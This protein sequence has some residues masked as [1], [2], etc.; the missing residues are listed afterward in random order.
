MIT[1]AL[2]ASRNLHWL[3]TTC[4]I[5]LIPGLASSDQLPA[6]PEAVVHAKYSCPVYADRSSKERGARELSAKTSDKNALACAADIR[7]AL[8]VEAANDRDAH[9]SALTSVLRYVDHVH[10][11]KN[12]D[13]GHTNWP[14]F[15]IRL[16]HAADMAGKLRAVAERNWPDDS[17]LSI[18]S[19][20]IQASLAG[21]DDPQTTLSAVDKLKRAVT[22]DPGALEGLGEFLIGRS[23]LALPPIFGGGATQALPYLEKAQ[24]IS[25]GNPR[26]LRYLA[27]VNDELGRRQ[28]ALSSLTALSNVQSRNVDLQLLAD[29]WRMG[30]GLATRMQ[31]Q[32]LADKFGSERTELIRQHPGLLVRKIE[33]VIGHG[34]DNPIT[35]IP[36]YRGEPAG[37]H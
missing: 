37:S 14:E 24:K 7:Y 1:F 18:L 23:Y 33:P 32:R 20:G 9:V 10:S 13:L 3:A 25:P 6:D 4:V 8:A 26:A 29:E 30:E 17:V 21:P 11:L 27:E 19:A 34:G 31:N 22:K 2:T 15:D 28:E 16:Q 36:Q 35:G 5:V 12:F